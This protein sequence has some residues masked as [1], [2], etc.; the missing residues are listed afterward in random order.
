M[1]E[2]YCC[3][4]VVHNSFSY[5]NCLDHFMKNMT[6]Q[7]FHLMSSS[8]EWFPCL[9]PLFDQSSR[10]MLQWPPKDSHLLLFTLVWY[11]TSLWMRVG[12]RLPS[13]NK[14]NVLNVTGSHCWNYVTL[15][16]TPSQQA[17]AGDFPCEPDEVGSCA[18]DTDK[19]VDSPQDLN[20]T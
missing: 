16:K 17:G 2:L 9:F 8:C 20:V 3:F 13:S 12:L 5:F 1:P 11:P 7:G 6:F 10:Q 19:S 14:E 18:E 4:C 15:S